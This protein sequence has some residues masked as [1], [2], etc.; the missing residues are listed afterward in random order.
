M[1]K[2]SLLVSALRAADIAG[3]QRKLER[4]TAGA[5]Y[6]AAPLALS[7]PHLGLVHHHKNSRADVRP[8]VLERLRASNAQHILKDEVE[9]GHAMREYFAKKFPAAEPFLPSGPLKLPSDNASFL[10]QIGKVYVGSG[11][12][13]TGDVLAHELGHQR[14]HG[15]LLQNNLTLHSKDMRN[16]AAIAAYLGQ[17]SDNKHVR[18]LTGAMPHVLA[19]I[20]PAYEAA[21]SAKG[22]QLL[23]QH[24]ATGRELRSVAGRNASAWGTYAIGAMNSS[25]SAEAFKN[26]ARSRLSPSKRL[27]H[28]AQ[29]NSKELKSLGRKGALVGAGA[30]GLGLLAHHL[31][32]KEAQDMLRASSIRSGHTKS[33]TS[34]A[35]SGVHAVAQGLGAAA[36][37]GGITAAG[38]AAAHMVDAGT[39]A[40]DFRKMLTNPYN[41]DL[42]DMYRNDPKK[43][44][45]A[46]NSLR[47]TNP[48]FSK[49]P[50]VAGLYMRKIVAMGERDPSMA[51]SPLLESLQHVSKQPSMLQ[52]IARAGGDSASKAYLDAQQEQRQDRRLKEDFRQRVE[53]EHLKN[54][55]GMKSDK[56]RHARSVVLE[57]HK[58]NLRDISALGNRKVDGSGNFMDHTYRDW[59]NEQQ[60]NPAVS[61]L[62]KGRI[63]FQ[64]A[65]DPFSRHQVSGQYGGGNLDYENPESPAHT[66]GDGAP[67]FGHPFRGQ[68]MGRLP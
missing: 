68:A 61:P 34:A 18:K 30:A 31:H 35:I 21:A 25:L 62:R 55:L 63:S 54:D 6:L 43:F 65:A 51:A 47:N 48:E 39:K 37:A 49:D 53:L 52:E 66:F 17:K 56:Q 19:A 60:S 57:T 36:A 38:M 42:G 29:D 44:V 20:T 24:G 12:P 59:Y 33:A 50:M 46:F 15:G 22:L 67:N 3:N 23:H 4:S 16:P 64:T 10:P 58:Q 9:A 45:S 28:W 14:I 26:Y 7:L 1:P 5:Y 11:L 2:D 32:E 27:L 41:E 40:H 8:E 13:D